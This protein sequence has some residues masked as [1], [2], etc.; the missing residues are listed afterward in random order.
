MSKIKLTGSNSGYVEIDSA[1]DAGNLTLTLPTSGVRLLSNTDNVFSGITTTGELDI[2]GKIDVSTDAVIARNLSVGGI[3]THTGTTTLSDDVTFTGASYNVVWD[4]SDNQLEFGDNA[5]ISFGGSSDL[6]IYH[7]GNRS[8]I[9]DTGTGELRMNGSAIQLR[10]TAQN[11][12]I[13]ATAN[14]SVDLYFNQN[15][16]FETTNTGAIVTGICTATSFS[17]S[18]ANLTGL[19]TPLSNRNL[20][21]NGAMNV[22][23]RGVTSTATGFGSVDRFAV[24]HGNTDEAPTQSQSDVGLSD[25]PFTEQG[26]TKCLKVTNGN[27]TSGAGN[28]DYIEINYKCEA[29]DIRNSGWNYLSGSSFI[30]LSY[31]VR[32]SVAQTYTAWIT[33]RDGTR[34]N[35]VWSYALAANTWTKITK[36]IPGNSGLTINN[37][38][39]AAIELW[40][41]QYYGTNYTQASPPGHNTGDWVNNDSETVIDNTSTWYTTNNATFELTG[42]QL[43]VGSV[44]TPF[45]HRSIGDELIRCR[46]YYQRFAAF[47]DH[48]HFGVAR[49]ESNTARTGLV[50]PVPMRA[51]PTVAC[52]GSRT[53]RGDGGYNSESTS[54]PSV[55]NT[56]TWISE[57]NMYTV[58]F[59]GHSL[60]HNRMYCLMSKTTSTNALTLDSEL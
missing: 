52:N 17:G 38:N 42:V 59:P 27:Q 21:I 45:E 44:A 46:R 16:K 8:I 47:S 36:V 3:T 33:N 48:Y 11:F 2:N 41:Q 40:L 12:M 30:T 23:Q 37:D 49:A 53:F 58:D 20:I 13:N 54:T 7:D 43:E 56:G 19:V 5:K 51:A 18:G 57:S 15:K 25:L 26:L 1:A 34:K 35:F 14:D 10:D 50:I 28:T 39:G 4:K 60:T 31:Y 32:S 55:Y 6:Q 24:Y 9:S 29:Q 22:A